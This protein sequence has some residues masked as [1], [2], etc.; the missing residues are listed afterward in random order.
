MRVRRSPV[1]CLLIL[2]SCCVVSPVGAQTFTFEALGGSAY[3]LPTPL[4]VQQN[5]FPDLRFSAHYD[6]KP[7]GPYYPYYSWRAS[8]W[9][10]EHTQAWEL[11]QVHHRLFLANNP[12]EIQFFAIHFGYNFYM[13]GHA[14]KRG[15]F[16][17]HVDGGILICS[18][19]NTVRGRV[20]S[21]QGTGI[22]DSG[23]T[24]AGG[25]GE[26]AVSRDFRLATHFSIVGDA[27]LLVGRARV[28]VADGSATVP[29]VGLHGKGGIKV[30]F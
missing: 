9:N 3:N 11:T 15:K 8:F 29:N 21:T 22:L 20:L 14:W 13:A 10:A 26:V 5:G 12:P 27:A 16:I 19:E 4:T 30:N 17:Y 24:L 1:P 25:G 23:Y 6:T 2:L 18:P 28:P 7:F